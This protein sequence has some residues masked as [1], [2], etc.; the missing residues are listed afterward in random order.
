VSNDGKMST[1]NK[2]NTETW[3]AK[4]LTNSEMDCQSLDC[5][6]L[7]AQVATDLIIWL[8][9]KVKWDRP[10]CH[11]LDHKVLQLETS[12]ALDSITLWTLKKH[13]RV[14][15]LLSSRQ[16]HL[17]KTELYSIRRAV[18]LAKAITLLRFLQTI[19]TYL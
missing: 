1:R 8:V 13:C 11:G 5:K 17:M 18:N 3:S 15:E 4:M 14:K 12:S 2:L 7:E 6:Q 16:N 19:L 10:R 9:A